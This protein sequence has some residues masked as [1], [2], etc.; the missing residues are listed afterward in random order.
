[1]STRKEVPTTIVDDNSTAQHGGGEAMMPSY[2]IP[3]T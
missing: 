1:M 2:H 3:E